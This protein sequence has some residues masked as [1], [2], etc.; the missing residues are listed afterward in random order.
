MQIISES[1]E[2]YSPGPNHFFYHRFRSC[3]YFT[4][5]SRFSSQLN[6]NWVSYNITLLTDSAINVQILSIKFVICHSR[7]FSEKLKK[8]RKIDL[9][10]LSLTS[11]TRGISSRI[12]IWWRSFHQMRFRITD[13]LTYN[14]S[15][16]DHSQL[17]FDFLRRSTFF[18]S[19][20]QLKISI[21]PRDANSIYPI[22]F[23]VCL[24]FYENNLF[25]V[26]F[27]YENHES[28]KSLGDC[29][30]WNSRAVAKCKIL[31]FTCVICNLSLSIDSDVVTVNGTQVDLSI[32][33][34]GTHKILDVEEGRRKDLLAFQ[35]KYE[36][37][38]IHRC[39]F[40]LC[41]L[42]I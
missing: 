27:A 33:L 25:F 29:V 37:F 36:I 34:L 31:F 11:Q 7:V 39:L 1:S 42:T 6:S 32:L 22:R 21:F 28:W 20:I 9:F 15:N 19:Q 35:L 23:S 4:S 16:F 30:N 2:K 26:F 13:P 14:R 40:V 18:R 41:N 8:N 5:E 38:C 17:E 3:R 10:A 24:F 12:R